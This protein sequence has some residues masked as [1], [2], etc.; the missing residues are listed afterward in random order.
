MIFGARVQLCAEE[1]RLGGTAVFL[2]NNW[3]RHHDG[4]ASQ[5]MLDGFHLVPLCQGRSHDGLLHVYHELNQDIE[6]SGMIR[7]WRSPM[8]N[9]RSEISHG[10]GNSNTSP[11]LAEIL[12]LTVPESWQCSG[13]PGQTLNWG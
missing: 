2:E 1:L 8:T 13:R 11:C 12:I 5:D 4:L 7:N 3:Q 9:M 6:S 10:V